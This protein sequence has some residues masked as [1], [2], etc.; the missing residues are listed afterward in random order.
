MRGVRRSF[1]AV[2]AVAGVDLVFHPGE[3]VGLVGH[4]GAGKSTLVNILAGTLA[5][6]EGRIELD[7]RAATPW[8][9]RA[10]H[11]AGLRTVFQELSLCPNLRVLENLRLVHGNLGGLGWRSEAARL[12]RAGLDRIFPGHGIDPGAVVGSLSIS[13]RQMVE[14]ARAYTVTDRPVRLVILDE[15]TSSLDARA[16]S[17]LLRHIRAAAAE[18]TSSVLI[19]HRLDEVLG[20]TDRVVVMRDG[21]V[22]SSGEASGFTRTTLVERMGV[23]EVEGGGAAATAAATAGRPLVELPPAR[24][25]DVPFRAHAGEV[26]GLAGLAGHGQREL[27]LRVFRAGASTA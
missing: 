6:D 23:V 11:A 8:S 19:S 16:A 18:G 4:N 1:G 7:G 17:Q 12:I 2:Q 24:A 9:V 26:V 10:A 3:V 21:G 15:P 13:E 22:V 27:L 5:P 14:I 20:H 25:G